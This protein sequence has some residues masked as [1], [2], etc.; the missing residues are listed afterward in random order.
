MAITNTKI[1]D[2]VGQEKVLS[3]LISLVL[4]EKNELITSGLAAHSPVVDAVANG[5]P[6]K[7]SIPF[8]LPLSTDEYNISTDD[9]NTA[10]SVGKLSAAEFSVL[11]HDLNYAWGDADLQRLVTQYNAK[12]GIHAGIADYWN[13]IFQKIGVASVKG[14]QAYIEAAIAAGADEEATEAQE[15][16][17]EELSILVSGSNSTDF[18]MDAVYQAAATAGNYSDMFNVM[19]VSPA[20]YAKFQS[21]EQNGFIPASKTDTRFAEYHGFTLLKS[22][23]FGDNMTVV[24]RLGG[25]AFGRGTVENA[26]E[27]ERVANGGNGAGADILHSRESVVIHP[28]GTDYVGSVAPNLTALQTASNWKLA[29][30]AEQFGFRFL[31]HKA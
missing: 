26:L 25:L 10:G 20:R 6:R 3:G 13:S 8:L 19:I 22:K 18:S 9:I 11:R 21:Q 27:V 12:V 15:E 7:S 30:P 2:L 16:L 28:Q 4:A 1:S 14:V 23:A 29:V 17:A 24:G 31:K 5:G